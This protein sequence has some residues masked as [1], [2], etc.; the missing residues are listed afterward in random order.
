MTEPE[1]VISITRAEPNANVV[2]VLRKL[3]ADAET[4][5]LRGLIY[6]GKYAKRSDHEAMG[7]VDARDVA[8]ATLD[9]QFEVMHRGAPDPEDCRS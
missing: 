7:E 3:L 5:D 4:G 6:V 9:L 2:E 1:R 8:L